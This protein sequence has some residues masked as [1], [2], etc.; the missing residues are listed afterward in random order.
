MKLLATPNSPYCRIV[1]VCA[2]ELN[3]DIDI[4]FVGLRDQANEIL[5]INPTGKVPTLINDHGNAFSDTRLICEELQALAEA[6]FLAVHDHWQRRVWEGFS[7]GFLDGIAVWVREERRAPSDKS[8]SVIDLERARANRCLAYLESNWAIEDMSI[9]F[10]AATLVS[11]LE[12]LQTRL[13]PDLI[14]QSA[15]LWQW[16]DAIGHSISFQKTRPESLRVN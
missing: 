4:E 9:D 7:I 2:L 10:T 14:Q 5:Q 11:A 3:L 6:S 8:E 16:Y 12:L 13:A 1:R 15:K